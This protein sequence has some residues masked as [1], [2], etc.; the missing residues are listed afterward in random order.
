MLHQSAFVT[1]IGN[2]TAVEKHK[3]IMK[4]ALPWHIVER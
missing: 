4:Q 2:F 1:F 3:N